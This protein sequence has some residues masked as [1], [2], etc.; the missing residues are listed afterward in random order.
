M[1]SWVFLTTQHLLKLLKS[2]PLHSISVAF[3]LPQVLTGMNNFIFHE[4]LSS[5]FYSQKAKPNPPE[6]RTSCRVP[7]WDGMF[8]S[9]T[10]L[11]HFT[12]RMWRIARLCLQAHGICCPG[13]HLAPGTKNVVHHLLFKMHRLGK[14]HNSRTTST[15]CCLHPDA[16]FPPLPPSPFIITH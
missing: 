12:H 6:I 11:L 3:S 8:W 10:L 4:K 1:G 16:P 2:H 15:F 9:L 5:S 13:F 14:V 7:P